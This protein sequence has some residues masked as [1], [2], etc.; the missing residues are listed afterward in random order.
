MGKT[1]LGV[2][3]VGIVHQRGE[4]HGATGGQGPARPPQVQGAGVAVPDGFFAGAGRV[5]G[6]QGQGDFDEFF[7]MIHSRSPAGITMHRHAL[8]WCR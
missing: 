1:R 2:G 7:A 6:F 4:N 8:L 5:D 3:I